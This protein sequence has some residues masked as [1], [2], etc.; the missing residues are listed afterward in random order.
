MSLVLGSSNQ[1]ENTIGWNKLILFKVFNKL[2][3]QSFLR[4][5]EFL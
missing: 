1:K 5:K 4:K 2:L 3:T